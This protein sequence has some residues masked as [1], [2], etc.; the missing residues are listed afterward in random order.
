MTYHDNPHLMRRVRVVSTGVI[1]IDDVPVPSP[2]PGELLVQMVI[3]G[4]CGSDLHALQGHH[5]FM[6]FPFFP[7]HEIVGVVAARGR[8]V[9]T[10][11]VGD[12]I[13]IEP[14]LYCGTCKHCRAGRYNLCEELDVFGCTTPAGGMADYFLIAP[15]RVHLVPDEMSD[16]EA[17]MIEP[18]ATPVHAVR[19]AAEDLAGKSV[20]VLGAGTIGLLTLIAARAHGAKTVVVT[21]LLPAKRERAMRLGADATFDAAAPDMVQA[22]RTQLGE[23]ADV[24]FDCVAIQATTTQAINLA[25][26]GGTVVV[27][28]VAPGPVT[29]PLQDIQDKQVRIQGSAMYTRDDFAESIRIITDGLIPIEEIVTQTL[30]LDQAAAA[31][32]LASNGEHVKVGLV[33][34]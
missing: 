4:V 33:G 27:V 8:D 30:P 24:V 10:P 9:T 7:G 25:L 31:F 16:R 21:D 11:N 14:N 15:D 13:V 2:S 1:E 12:R 22:V 23:S 34:I 32:N 3:V 26:K 5:P 17:L 6:G 28:G 18:L 29:V 19:M 20:V